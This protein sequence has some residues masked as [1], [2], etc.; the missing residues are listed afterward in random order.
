MTS[1]SSRLLTP[2]RLQYCPER[3]K[4][5]TKDLGK[6][7]SHY[8]HSRGMIFTHLPDGRPICDNVGVV[9]LLRLT[10]WPSI[11]VTKSY[12][13]SPVSCAGDFSNAWA[14]ANIPRIHI[15]FVQHSISKDEGK[16]SVD[17]ILPFGSS[18]PPS[19]AF[20]CCLASTGVCCSTS[21]GWVHDG[22][23][24]AREQR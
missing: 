11:S 16:V 18:R 17:G 21:P 6:F 10:L 19:P 3:R 14:E 5:L 20:S 1:A 13:P 12:F 23:V 24:N 4:I 15:C 9:R 22:H 7:C 8:L 2:S